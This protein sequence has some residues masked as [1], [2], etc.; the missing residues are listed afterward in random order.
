MEHRSPHVRLTP[1]IN[2]FASRRVKTRRTHPRR[3]T[4]GDDDM[5]HSDKQI[6]LLHFAASVMVAPLLFCGAA[7]AHSQD[8]GVTING[9]PVQFQ[10][11]GPQ[12][13]NGRTMVPVRGVLEKLGADVSYDNRTRTVTASTP[14]IDIQLKVGS[15]TAI[16]NA[17]SVALDVPAQSIRDHTFVPLRF[18]G[19]ALGADIKWDG[20]TRTVIIRT[21]DAAAVGAPR[22]DT[23]IRRRR[24]EGPPD[25]GSAPVINSFSHNGGKWLRAGET[26]EA[27]LDG[28][29]G[30]EASFR[31]PGLVEDV[32]MR[33][34]SPG[35]YVGDWQVPTDKPMQLKS[36]AVIGSLRA[37]G[38]TAP[39]LQA[40]EAVSVDAVPPHARD[41]TPDD[42][43]IVT[44]RRPNIS[45]VFEDQGSG[46]ERRSIRLFLNGA[47][48][49]GQA[50][51]TRDFISYR[52]DA[53]L[54]AGPQQVELRLADAAGNHDERRWRFMEQPG[55]A[56]GIQSVSDNGD[57]ALQPGDTLRAEMTGT[58]GGRAAFSVGTIQDVPM[59]EDKPGRYVA[60]YTIRRGDDLEGKPMLFHLVTPDGQRFQQSSRNV[61]RAATGA[62]LTPVIV[63]PGAHDVPANPLI[64]RGKA[65]PNSQVHVRVDYRNRVLG[66]LALQGTAADAIVTADR[67]G[68]W[69]TEPISL[70]GI[71]GSRGVEYTITATGI[72]A[73]GEKSEAATVKFRSP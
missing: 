57:R 41:L 18:L 9:E 12:Q 63:S 37:G 62:P 67:A 70:G 68:N 6:G 43:S 4:Q 53:A 29:P 14:T 10:D 66:L 5:I 13:I 47:D 8:I 23:R 2:G 34:A 15:R 31:I 26:L 71:F 59:R 30:G 16:V 3:S 11:I 28:T 69:R 17:N 22:D 45:A 58:P 19:E 38:R 49:T 55:A 73:A 61:L 40:G 20:A 65:A 56:A 32:P 46:I 33:E 39:L 1:E 64:V 35:H 21:K 44:D 42:K 25:A 51:V 24:R 27:T 50:T 72:N 52:P 60:E 7:S 54:Q 36:A 48:V